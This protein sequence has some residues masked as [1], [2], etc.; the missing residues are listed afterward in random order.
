MTAASW[1]AF[2]VVLDHDGAAGVGIVMWCRCRVWTRR[3]P[4]HPAQ[5][6][7]PRSPTR[8][9][10]FGSRTRSRCTTSFQWR[11]RQLATVVV[12]VAAAALL[13]L[14]PVVVAAAA[15]VAP[16][17][18][19]VVALAAATW[20]RQPVLLPL[21]TSR[22]RLRPRNRRK[23]RRS[24]RGRRVMVPATSLTT[25][26]MTT[27]AMMTVTALA[28]RNVAQRRYAMSYALASARVL[29]DDRVARMAQRCVRWCFCPPCIRCSVQR[30]RGLNAEQQARFQAQAE[31]NL[32]GAIRL[33]EATKPSVF[34]T[35][36]SYFEFKVRFFLF[37][38]SCSAAPTAGLW[39]QHLRSPAAAPVAGGL[40]RAVGVAGRAWSARKEAARDA[41]GVRG[42]VSARDEVAAHG[43]GGA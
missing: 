18:V 28:R 29:L 15:V 16:L 17:L 26:A 12:V 8:F 10:R 9:V 42:A 24:V 13:P 43:G 37:F 38:L 21:R 6:R 4:Q 40:G 2:V 36:W 3:L 33:V 23:R 27:R 5:R 7:E 19:P 1:L 31:H 41:Q 34:R 11:L 22:W 30:S 32:E 20:V 14:V 35:A 25:T 39:R